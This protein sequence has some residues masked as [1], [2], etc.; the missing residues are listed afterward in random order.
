MLHLQHGLARVEGLERVFPY[1][2]VSIQTSTVWRVDGRRADRCDLQDRETDGA[3]SNEMP[4]RPQ[5]EPIKP[6]NGGTGRQTLRLHRPKGCRGL[7]DGPKAAW[8][9]AVLRFTVVE[10]ESR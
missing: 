2:F 8:T 7:A 9:A 5:I 3:L 6:R 4:S 10:G 1:P